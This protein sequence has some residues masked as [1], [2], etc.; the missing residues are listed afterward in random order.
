[1][2][3]YKTGG[4]GGGSSKIPSNL[5]YGTQSQFAALSSKDKD[6]IYFVKRLSN[7]D[8]YKA[9][10]CRGIYIGENKIYPPSKDGYDL[11][12][13]NMFFPD[14]NESGLNNTDYQLDTGLGFCSSDN[15]GRDW[16]LEFKATL[17]TT[18]SVSGDQV[19]CGCGSSNGWLYELYFNS[20]GSLCI[21][22]S[23]IS[24]GEKVSGANGH[25]MK[26]VFTRST[27]SLAIYKDNVL[28]TT[29]TGIGNPSANDNYELGICRYSN[30]YRFHGTI[31][32]LKF[33]W[34]S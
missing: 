11:Y 9:S 18:G 32:Y 14:S 10:N 13:E 24:D 3:W 25:D 30:S 2:A 27:S 1:M 17:T 21:Y 15:I 31:N 33:K 12:F 29:L 8:T 34:L 20:S 22:G 4:G 6:T 7:S 5:W 19:I 23:G 16:Q 28:Q 26:L